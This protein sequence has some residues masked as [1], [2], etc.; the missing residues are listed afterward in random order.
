MFSAIAAGKN[1]GGDDS[2]EKA[3]KA[4]TGI[5]SVFEPIAENHAVYKKLYV[6]YRQLHDRFGTKG[7]SGSM[8]NVMKDLLALRDQ[9]RKG[10]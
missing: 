4:M 9:V 2:I 1:S 5:S 8:Y 10:F 3:Q 7:W 6:L